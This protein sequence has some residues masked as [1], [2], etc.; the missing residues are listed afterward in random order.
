M[1][2]PSPA[3]HI[4]TAEFVRALWQPGD[5][6][7][8]RIPKYGGRGVAAGYFDDLDLLLGQVDQWDGKANVY[9]TLNPVDRALLA[10]ATN[11]IAKGAT[12]TTSDTNIVRRRWLL[13]DV[14]PVRPADISSTKEEAE[15][16][17][18]LALAVRDYLH[19]LG[20]PQP[21]VGMSG[22][23]YALLY[24]ID[25]P[26]DAEA[27]A[28]VAGVLAHLDG[29]FSSDTVKIDTTVSNAARIGCLFGTLKV[30][31]DSTPERPHRRSQI[32]VPKQLRPVPT[33]LL[34]ALVPA[35]TDRSPRPS[36]SSD[37]F[38][39]WVKQWLDAAG[40]AYRERPPDASGI[41][42]YRLDDC[43]FHPGDD[44]G[45]D[46]GVGE[47]PDGKGTGK[48]FHNRGAGNGWTEFRKALG[49]R[50]T[51][52]TTW[53]GIPSDT[54]WSEPGRIDVPNVPPFPVAALPEPYRAFAEAE[55][56]A[57]QTP[58]D[59]AGMFTLA[60]L[61]SVCAGNV[62]VEPVAGW[63]EPTCVFVAVA[64]EPGSRKS[65]A[66]RDVIAPVR[67]FEQE[68]IEDAL[69]IVTDANS[70]RRVAEARLARAEKQAA[71]A[72]GPEARQ[73]EMEALDLARDLAAM[74][75]AELP[76]LFTT[77]ATPEAIASLM[78][79]NGGVLSVLSAESG[80]F[81]IMAG[82]YSNGIP[83]LD[84]FLSGHAGDSIRIDR[85]NR[86]PEYIEAP[87]LTM[88]LAVQP[89]VLRQVA[90]V[91]EFT[92][93][94][95]LDRFLYALPV[96]NVG[97]RQTRPEPIPAGVRMAYEDAVLKLAR[98][99]RATSEPVVL[100]L[101]PEA[102]D[103]FIPW[104]EAMEP[105]RRPDADLG[106]LAGWSSKLDGAAARIAGLL[107]VAAHGPTGSI[108]WQSM[109]AALAVADY[110]TAHAIAVHDLMGTSPVTEDARHVIRWLRAGGR[111]QFTRRDLHRAMQQKFT[112]APEALDACLSLLVESEHIRPTP[113]EH[114]G[115]GRP[116]TT[117]FDVNPQVHAKVMTE[118][119]EPLGAA[120]SV[121]SV[122]SSALSAK[123]N[124][125]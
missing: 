95:L 7:E 54:P 94:G 85:R 63:R 108:G 36:T 114:S 16:A 59:M 23:G 116:T 60:A 24:S 10:R 107:H 101:D 13:V 32:A 21:M 96:G 79:A 72:S 39:G 98:E 19:G 86:P 113:T 5:V 102:V 18:A 28:L 80:V 43:P 3:T 77:D 42:W 104:R 2:S 93:R 25:L 110:L 78:A 75:P 74:P 38:T 9:V 58:L 30:K 69:P 64:M 106:P 57:T 83:N 82:R 105:R 76:R 37:G 67:T 35:A 123:G 29:R 115:P 27:T 12:S 87:A 99:V 111:Q 33:D 56:A 11:R 49:L 44:A 46:C 52:G 91:S 53:T 121:G 71:N 50:P 122:T 6:R 70:R 103:I 119:T 55:A 66:H 62:Q 92:G 112:G 100:P 89:F 1:A 65:A 20:W 26:N 4:P 84:V 41:V 68:L 48:C 117:T 40:V 124:R 47:A 17:R 15:A 61:A 31:G 22:N 8:V 73:L 51:G 81:G 45:G 88:G 120:L 34:S 90:K 97:Y 118:M 109:L 14:D 125:P